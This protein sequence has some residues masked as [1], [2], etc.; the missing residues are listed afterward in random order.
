M[1]VVAQ[2][3]LRVDQQIEVRCHFNC[4][5]VT[6][7]AV[8]DVVVEDGETLYRIKRSSDGTVLP[9]LFPDGYVRD[10]ESRLFT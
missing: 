7:F 2:V 5:W 3:P 10:G 4:S 1:A 9:A 6:G 8:A